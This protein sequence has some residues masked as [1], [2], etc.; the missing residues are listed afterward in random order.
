MS[1][2]QIV[3]K[4]I[5]EV[6][7]DKRTRLVESKIVKG[8]LSI[9]VEMFNPKSI[10]DTTF[11]FNKLFIETNKMVKLGIH[12]STINEDL[13]GVLRALNGD[14]DNIIDTIK[15]KLITYLDMNLQ[16]DNFEKSVLTQTIVDVEDDDFSR[17]FSDRKFLARQ[18]SDKFVTEFKEKYLEGLSDDLK[19]VIMNQID[20]DNFKRDMEDKYT[21]KLESMLDSIESKMDSK[22]RGIRDNVF[23]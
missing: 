2:K 15:E 12:E 11:F 16:M 8:R 9:L 4:N 7:T 6:K 21:T 23:S 18:L 19:E 1:L 5:N 20:T 14:N 22:L 3:K 13:I 10:I 17:V